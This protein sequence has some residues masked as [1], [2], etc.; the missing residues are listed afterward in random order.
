MSQ[1]RTV[2]PLESESETDPPPPPISSPLVDDFDQEPLSPFLASNQLDDLPAPL[3]DE[4]DPPAPFSDSAMAGLDDADTQ[5]D[6][7]DNVDLRAGGVDEEDGP[8][9]PPGPDEEDPPP[10]SDEEDP[11][12]SDSDEENPP[13][14]D[15]EDQDDPR[16][17]REDLKRNLRFISMLENATLAAQFN[18]DELEALRHP[19]ENSFSPSDDPD[20]LLSIAE[21][22]AH[23]NSSQKTYAASVLNHRRRTPEVKMLSYDQVKRR[24][25]RLSGVVTWQHDMCVDSCVGFTGPFTHLEACPRCHK[26]RYDPDKLAKSGGKKKVPQKSFTT[27]PVGPQL[28]SRWKSPGM[29]EKMHYRRNKTADVL[30]EDIDQADYIYDDILSGSDYLNAVEAGEIKD[31]DTVLMLSIDG[32]QLLRNKKSD[33][34]IYIWIILDLAPDQRYKI[35]NI[36]PGGVIPGPGK[37]KDLD[38]FLFPG[39]AH[40]CA[41]QKEGLNIWDGYKRVAAI[42]FLFLL[43]ILA[44][45]VGMAELT[46]SVG[47]HGRR[48]CRLLCSFFGRNKPG[49]S[50]YYPVLLLPLDSDN[51]AS[52]H[53]DVDI[54]EIES[55]NPVIYRKELDRVL[56]SSSNAEYRERRLETGIRK[57]SIFDAIPRILELPTCFPG[58]VM[59]QPVIN[60]TALMFDLFCDREGCRK[61]VRGAWDWAVLKGD[62]W[63][64]HGKAVADAAPWFPRSFD[65]T[66]RNPADKLS[67]GYKAWELLL[68]FYGLGP[69]LFYGILP[70]RYYQHYCKLVVAIRIFYQRQITHP[71]LELAHKFLLE[72]VVEFEHLYYQRKTEH[73]HFVRQCVHSLIHLGPET[74]RLGPPALSAQWTMER[75]IGV[76]GSL[77][78][79]PSNIFSN[80]R[81]QAKKVAEINAVVAMW[82]EI[83][84]KTGEPRG[85]LN[86]GQGYILLGPK[87][88]KPYPLSPAER[89]A[90]AT[91]YSDLP[92]EHPQTSVYRWGRLLIP[93]EQTARSR[94]KEVDRSSRAARTDR[95]VKVR[96]PSHI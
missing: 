72:W 44:D 23:A 24:V 66:P 7:F 6:D 85:S 73:L 17:A 9:P 87:D 64:A 2:T 45:A 84:I 93:T 54:L 46:G 95:N 10:E 88:T 3:S 57:A 67:S 78:R 59:H 16:V 83:E 36:V 43:L 56:T 27:F 51:P 41:L 28:Q 76:F 26:P 96:D 77:L 90:L 20:L 55:A 82:P 70:E 21:F 47:H 31:Y 75:V 48:G 19:Q 69:G 86:L 79:Q 29:A 61:G 37:P 65:R 30:R 32:A 71:Q 92:L 15:E 89:T 50:H 33:C 12:S 80:L 14:D 42:S 11:P 22:I 62:V 60:L 53:P 5:V 35:R 49:G 8:N 25:S 1:S 91:F 52:N 18:L 34:W 94:W 68:Y 38:S 13:S 58:D 63:K 40:V 4:E 81:E 74:I 39:L